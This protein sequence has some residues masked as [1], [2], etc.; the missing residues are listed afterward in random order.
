MNLSEIR[1]RATSLSSRLSSAKS[2]A[3]G[4]EAALSSARTRSIEASEAQAV[5]QRAAEDVQQRAHERVTALVS[6]CLSAVFDEPYELRLRVER[7]RGRTE[8]SL[9]LCRGG[10]ELDDPMDCAGGGVIDVAALAL[11]V[12]C[13]ALVRPAPRRFLALDEPLRALSVEFRPRA[14]ELLERLAQ[15]TQT[16]ILLITHDQAFMVGDVVRL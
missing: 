4:I 13:L 5:A 10:L 8:A 16:Q 6:K 2:R 15:E 1:A 7:K 11:R 9:V 14:A 3:A 12:A